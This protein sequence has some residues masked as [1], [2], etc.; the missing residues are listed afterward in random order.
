M[1]IFVCVLTINGNCFSCLIVVV[2]EF[3]YNKLYELKPT[4]LH[5]SK[6]LSTKNLFCCE[7][8]EIKKR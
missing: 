4:V 1:Q 7:F 6:K 5:T 2:I 8:S 3:N